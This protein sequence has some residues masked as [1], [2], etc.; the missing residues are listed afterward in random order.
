MQINTREKKWTD[1]TK[2][3]LMCSVCSVHDLHDSHGHI[4]WKCRVPNGA[5]AYLIFKWDNAESCMRNSYKLL[6]KK[7]KTIK[8]KQTKTHETIDPI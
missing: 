5:N 7:T 1:K 3:Q 2:N 8:Q 4:E 6:F